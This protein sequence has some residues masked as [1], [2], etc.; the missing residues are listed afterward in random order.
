ML[1]PT[2]T[3]IL[4][5]DGSNWDGEITPDDAANIVAAGWKFVIIRLNLETE[6]A[7]QLSIRQ[8]SALRAAGI[9]VLGYVWAYFEQAAARLAYDAVSLAKACGLGIVGLD[10]E[11]P[12]T[13]AM[14][15]VDWMAALIRNVV[16][17]GIIPLAYTYS[18]WPANNGLDL[19]PLGGV[20][21]WIA[22]KGQRLAAYQ[23]APYP[24]AHVVG[25]Q[26]GEWSDA[27]GQAFDTNWLVFDAEMAAAMN[28]GV[29]DM[30]TE[31]RV[32]E[33]VNEELSKIPM[34]LAQGNDITALVRAILARIDAAGAALLLE[35]AIPAGRPTP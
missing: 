21:W 17:A 30:L 22:N 19:A 1:I 28:G 14:L 18:Y 13:A 34:A 32:R 10:F 3:A 20:R 33:I 35:N 4:G 8:C 7:G 12:V 6:S 24:G 15:P 9:P 16:D 25:Q 11:A 5:L 26:F 23:L 2:D 27:A 31:E 29:T